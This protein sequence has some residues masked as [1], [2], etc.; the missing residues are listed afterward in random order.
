MKSVRKE[1][2]VSGWLAYPPAPPKCLSLTEFL[3]LPKWPKSVWV[4]GRLDFV[5]PECLE[6]GK[7]GLWMDTHRLD[8]ECCQ[9]PVL[10]AQ[11]GAWLAHEVLKPGDWVV[12]AFCFPDTV[13]SMDHPISLESCELELVAPIVDLEHGRQLPDQGQRSRIQVEHFLSFQEAVSEFFNQQ[14]FTQ[15]ETPTLVACPGMEPHLSPFATEFCMGHRRQTLY[16]PTSPELHL[17]KLLGQ[18]WGPLFE[19][20]T[21]FRNGELSDQHQ[22]EFKMLEW[23]RPFSSLSA[24]EDDISQL[25]TYLQSKGFMQGPSNQLEIVSVSSLFKKHLSFDLRPET[26]LGEL[27]QV[28]QNLGLTEALKYEDWDDVFHV[29]FLTKIEP[30]LPAEIPLVVKDYPPSQAALARI[31]SQGWADRF[32]LYWRGF[33]LANA[34]HELN[35]PLEQERRFKADQEKR[36]AI[37]AELV[38]IDQ[39]FMDMMRSGMPP[40]AGIALGLERL[41]L[42]CQGLTSLQE[43]RAFP[44]S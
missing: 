22:P 32:E 24:I 19:I 8:I 38:P 17:K 42:A 1:Y 18:G 4:G 26:Q 6:A 29:L 35:D 15:V 30:S 43:I 33:E 39:E 12:L 28:A 20:K 7:F 40:S 16:L 27:K 44:F 21:C 2:L 34:F 37:G 14:S 31:N 41:Y 10:K 11:N 23:Y 3:K 36:K 13:E 9:Q 25:L 5:S